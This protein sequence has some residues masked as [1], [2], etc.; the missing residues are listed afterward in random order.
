MLIFF[1]YFYYVLDFIRRKSVLS[2][3]LILYKMLYISVILVEYVWGCLV[4][5]D[6]V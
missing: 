5:R 3:F 1:I 2:M 4:Y 6:L